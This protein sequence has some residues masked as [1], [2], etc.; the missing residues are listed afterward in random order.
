MSSSSC[1]RCLD[2]QC[3]APIKTPDLTIRYAYVTTTTFYGDKN[4][5]EKATRRYNHIWLLNCKRTMCSENE[6][7]QT[8]TL[9]TNT[10]GFEVN[11]TIPNTSP[12]IVVVD[13]DPEL[14]TLV[15]LLLRR[16]GA[17]VH[18]FTSSHSAIRYLLQNT[19]DIIILDLMLPDINGLDLLRQIR[20]Q[21]RFDPVPVLILSA[22]ADPDTIRSGLD[23]GANGY[24]T[25][26]YIANSLI[27]RVRLLLEKKD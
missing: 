22:K 24:V 19:P 17:E 18:T 27:D 10:K 15:T 25:K 5:V 4:H 3:D 2:K 14:L 20:K 16:I 9:I 13:D 26:P 8:Q 7:Q 21:R 6:Q 1:D 11:D 12:T 23:L